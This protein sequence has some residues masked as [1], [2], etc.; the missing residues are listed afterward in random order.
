[1][2]ETNGEMI[3]TLGTDRHSTA[4]RI[5]RRMMKEMPSDQKFI[6]LVYDGPQ[7]PSWDRKCSYMSDAP[8]DDIAKICQAV[9]EQIK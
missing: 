4:L 1:M 2:K 8:R 6:L 5:G 7:I 9:S 3:E